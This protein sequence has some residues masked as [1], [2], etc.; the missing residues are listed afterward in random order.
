MKEVGSLTQEECSNI[1]E[2]LEKKI[3]LENLL[4]ILSESQEVYEKV[5]RDYKN[6]VE[7]YEKWWIDTSDKYMWES[8]DNSFWSIDFKSRKVYLVDE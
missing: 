1:E 3:A 7:E 2:L 4:K 6:I 8:T 5:D